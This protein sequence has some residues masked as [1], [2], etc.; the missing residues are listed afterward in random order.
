MRLLQA[1]VRT[2]RVLG[3]GFRSDACLAA[4]PEPFFTPVSWLNRLL[5]LLRCS[6]A[7]CPLSAR[8]HP[9]MKAPGLHS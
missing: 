6:S 3:S 8:D 9:G 5:P 2:C 4:A 1:G 7:A